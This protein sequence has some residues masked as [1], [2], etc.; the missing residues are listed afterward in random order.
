MRALPLYCKYTYLVKAYHFLKEEVI[1]TRDRL[2][3]IFI[4][5]VRYNLD[6]G[7]RR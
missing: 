3:C 7:M 6:L 5:N 1:K 4:I 2:L